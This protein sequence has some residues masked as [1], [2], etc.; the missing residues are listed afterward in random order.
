ML[1][2]A[3]KYSDCE[4]ALTFLRD[5]LGLSEHNVFRGEAGAIQHAQLRLG[6]GI[7]MFGPDTQQG[8]FGQFMISPADTGGRATVSLYAVMADVS[9]CFARVRDAGTEIL[10]PL[11]AQDH[12][13]SAFTCRDPGGHVW[14]V[15]DY[16]PQS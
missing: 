16:D 10:L 11:T 6:T 3:T 12:G 1:I 7:F 8:D 2:A 13:G 5:V 4:A 14:T 15:G 9:G